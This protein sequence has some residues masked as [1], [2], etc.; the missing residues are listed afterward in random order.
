[1]ASRQVHTWRACVLI[2][3]TEKK[4]LHVSSQRESEQ[5]NLWHESRFF[6]SLIF[7]QDEYILWLSWLLSA[8]C[9]KVP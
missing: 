8:H 2:M 3:L 7:A 4:A 9:D 6:I 1:M 5:S